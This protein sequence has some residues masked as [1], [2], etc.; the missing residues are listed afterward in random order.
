VP[1]ATRPEGLSRGRPFLL[2]TCCIRCTA[3]PTL[4][5]CS[6]VTACAFIQL[7]VADHQGLAAILAA[8]LLYSAN[9][10][11][12]QRSWGMKS[13]KLSLIGV[14]SR[15]LKARL[16]ACSGAP[17]V[18]VTETTQEKVFEQYRSHFK[19][20]REK[21]ATSS[22]QLAINRQHHVGWR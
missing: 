10:A 2:P 7:L 4:N 9:Q 13:H 15:E 17:A 12:V 18:S 11:E 3:E 8:T 21:I 19:K 1:I 5:F 6:T 14:T 20:A 22:Y 16:E